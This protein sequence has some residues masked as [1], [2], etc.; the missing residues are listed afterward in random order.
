MKST[1]LASGWL[2]CGWLVAPLA[3]ADEGKVEYNRDVRPILSNHCFKCH[4]PDD[5]ARKSGLRLDLREEALKPA[6]SGRKP[7]IPGRPDGSSV[8]RRVNEERE[9]HIMPPPSEKKPLTA[10]QKETLRRWIAEGA[11]YQ[12]HWAFVPPRR[13]ALPKIS[14]PKWPRNGIDHFILAALDREAL[15]PS[16]EADRTTLIRRVTLDL[17]G[18]PPTPQEVQAFLK[19]Q[20]PDAY[21]KVVDR[22]LSSAH[23]GERLAVD[24]L[25]AARYADTH[26]FHLDSG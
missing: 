6:D 4:G 19:D 18:L 2:L 17:T 14:D 8:I 11:E 22:L 15:K 13:P 9:S 7:I 16:K 3:A 23:H 10:A 24:W 21:E 20:A 26:G 5:K 12:P 1:L 25:D